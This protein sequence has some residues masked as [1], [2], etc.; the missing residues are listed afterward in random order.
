MSRDDL[1]AIMS[2]LEKLARNAISDIK[3]AANYSSLKAENDIVFQ[4]CQESVE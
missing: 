2:R 1:V 4:W 3:I